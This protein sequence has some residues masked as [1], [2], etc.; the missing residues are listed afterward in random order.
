[1][2]KKLLTLFILGLIAASCSKEQSDENTSLNNVS[3]MNELIIDDGFDWKTSHVVHINLQ[4]LALDTEVNKTVVFKNAK[5]E[6]ILKKFVSLTDDYVFEVEYPDHMKEIT[7]VAGG[8]T[9]TSRVSNG[10]VSFDFS[11]PD[12]RSDLDPQDQ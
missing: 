10:Q 8:M 7:M 3:N 1:M 6:V 2:K 4:G 5:G 9:K 11:K 12:D